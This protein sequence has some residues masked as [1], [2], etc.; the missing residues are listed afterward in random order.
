M[1]RVRHAA[2]P[3][4]LASALAT[5]AQPIYRCP[6][7]GYSAT[8]CEG[9]KALDAAG[10]PTAEQRRQA[11]DAARRDAALADQMAAERREREHQTAPRGAANIGPVAAS[12]KPPASATKSHPKS[13][14]KRAATASEDPKLSAPMRTLDTAPKKP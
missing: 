13:K 4:L 6:S 12:P 2:L 8:P 10:V 1:T 5:A 14:P 9:G 11:Q 3:L 7:G